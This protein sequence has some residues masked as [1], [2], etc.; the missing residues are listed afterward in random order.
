M[1]FSSQ[2]AVQ[3]MSL[4]PVVGQQSSAAGKVTVGLALHWPC[5]TD[6][7]GF[8]PNRISKGDNHL[9]NTPNVVWYPFIFLL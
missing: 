2:Q 6:S 8:R 9:T 1:E 3:F 5:V 4:I 7:S